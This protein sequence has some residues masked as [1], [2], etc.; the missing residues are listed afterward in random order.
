MLGQPSTWCQMSWAACRRGL[1]REAY[2]RADAS[3]IDDYGGDR[4]LKQVEVFGIPAL[5][6]DQ[7]KSLEAAVMEL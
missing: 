7:S 5:T 4:E 6:F 3:K 2:V 1:L